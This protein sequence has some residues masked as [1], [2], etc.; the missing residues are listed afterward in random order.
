MKEHLEKN[1]LIPDEQKGCMANC[2][3]TLDQLLIDQMVL[4]DAKWNKKNLSCAWIDYR[5][6]FDS[7]PH[8]YLIKM[9]EVHKFDDTIINFFK[10][11]MDIWQTI[12]TINNNSETIRSDPLK[13][14]TGIFQG[15][16]PS[17][18]H[19]VIC[20]LPLSW[21]LKKANLGY[22]IGKGRNKLIHHLLFMDDLKLYAA[23]DAQLESLLSIVKIF[24]DDIKMSFG[25]DK[26]NKITIKRGKPTMQPDI[27]LYD[28]EVIKE[29]DNTE[30]YK[31]LGVDENSGIC[32]KQMKTKVKNEYFH[33]IKKIL[34]TKLNGKNIITAINSFAMPALSYGFAIL[35]WSITELDEIDRNTRKLL[36]KFHILHNKSDIHRLYIPRRE[37]GRGL[38]SALIQYKKAIISIAHYLANSRERLICTLVEWNNTRGAKSLIRKAETYSREVGLDFQQLKNKDKATSKTDVKNG[39][40]ANQIQ[41]YENMPLHGQFARELN[42]PYI[43][44]E[45]S[46]AWIK[47][48]TLKGVTE[49]TTFAI[50]EQAITTKYIE[51]HIHKSTDNDTCRLCNQYPETIHHILSGCPILAP[52]KYTERH[53]NVGKLL[54]IN[55]AKK[56]EL[57]TKQEQWY[58]YEPPP[59][60]ENE[61]TK[62]LWNFYIQTDHQIAHNK[63]DIL[64]HN[65]DE[66]YLLIIDM[67]IPSDYNVVTKRAEKLRNYTD[68]AVEL[69]TLWHIRNAYII[70]FIIGTTGIIHNQFYKDIEHIPIN[71]DIKE[72]QKIAILGSVNIARAFFQSVS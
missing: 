53:D 41:K 33:R 30:I 58:S 66:N 46:I 61:H 3:G 71:I 11:S 37:S 32:L 26:C 29:L 16:S 36:K 6:A 48:S 68:L 70:P 5:K 64:L 8:D 63:P 57:L 72:Y 7:I 12:L 47:G 54:F 15:D 39:I 4:E 24:S 25:L 45:A 67:A 28:G 17:G 52:N 51:T 55:L 20:L 43:D 21:L 62:L 13:I 1:K 56:F 42:A 14:S 69:K 49:A 22:Y 34:K 60:L 50:Q 9:L 18:L 31:Y 44:K 40:Q 23:N 65:K 38:L 2:Y 10:T 59:V 19:F 27:L 35:D